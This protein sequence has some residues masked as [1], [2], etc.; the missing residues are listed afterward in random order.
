MGLNCGSNT[1]GT[2]VPPPKPV[3]AQEMGSGSESCVKRQEAAEE[4]GSKQAS[5]SSGSGRGAQATCWPSAPRSGGWMVGAECSALVAA[6]SGRAKVLAFI[7]LWRD[8]PQET[9]SLGL[10][11]SSADLAVSSFWFHGKKPKECRVRPCSS[12]PSLT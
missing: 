12:S 8:E 3:K 6:T 7:S 10:G 4:G 1:L 9:V 11:H 2:A 5:L